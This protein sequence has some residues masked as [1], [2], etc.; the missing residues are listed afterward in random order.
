MIVE[1]DL[2]L[3]ADSDRHLLDAYS[4][5]VTGVVKRIAQSVTHINVEKR[6]PHPRSK[7]MVEQPASGSGFVISSD[8]FI[9]TN[10]HVVE[11][12][13]TIKV[14]FADQSEYSATLVG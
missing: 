12:A 1:N 3:I 6:V 5:T 11:G 10:H 7:E 14:A 8:G 13:S 4:S 2:N 9:V